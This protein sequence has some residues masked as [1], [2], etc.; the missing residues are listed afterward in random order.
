MSVPFGLVIAQVALRPAGVLGAP[1]TALTVNPGN[2]SLHTAGQLTVAFSVPGEV[3]PA[4]NAATPDA[5][6]H[7][8]TV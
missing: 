1:G 4:T 7:V 6:A 8:C 5:A 2:G 3:F